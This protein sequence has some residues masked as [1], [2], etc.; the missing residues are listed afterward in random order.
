MY[1]HMIWVFV[2]MKIFLKM[3]TN[4]TNSRQL[5][6]DKIAKLRNQ[7]GITI[8]E[9]ASLADVSPATIVNIEQ[10]KFSPRIDVMQKLLTEL[11]AEIIIK[12]K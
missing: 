10:G 8:R 12:E 9:L 6:G 5:L 11:D 4:E 7:R 1:I 3:K 2:L